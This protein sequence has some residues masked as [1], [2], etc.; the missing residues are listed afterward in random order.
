[1]CSHRPRSVLTSHFFACY[2]YSGYQFIYDNRFYLSFC[3]LFVLLHV[4]LGHSITNP[5]HITVLRPS[6][7]N[8]QLEFPNIIFHYTLLK[9]PYFCKS[10]YE[11]YR[12]R[13]FTE[14][15][16]LHGS[17]ASDGEA[18]SFLS[19][20]LHAKN[21]HHIECVFQRDVYCR[22]IVLINGIRCCNSK[23]FLSI[24]QQHSFKTRF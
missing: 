7:S 12:L 8:K 10:I 4:R 5:W 22:T 9:N 2:N 24:T 21:I 16:A 19:L 1:M 18:L 6:C 14:C 3:C 15:T 17:F 20:L 13:V 23:A 11:F